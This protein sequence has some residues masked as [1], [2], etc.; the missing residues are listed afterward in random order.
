MSPP[1]AA[2]ARCD[3]T[4]VKF[5]TT[6]PEGRICR[7]CYQRAT[8]I[9]GTCPAC[10]QPRL[11]PGLIDAEPTCTD[12]A[13]IPKDFHCTR[14]GRE[15]EPVRTGLCAHCCLADDLALL[16][17]DGTG[18]IAAPLRPLFAALTTQKH[19]RSARAWLT[20]NRHAEQLLRDIAQRRAP[21]AHE[22]FR[23][24]P[25]PQKVAFL[26]ELCLEH[27]LLGRVNL[28]IERFQDWLESKA[29][30]LPAADAR[31]I[32]QYARWVHLNRMRH[33]ERRGELKK[34]TFLAAKQSTTMAIGFLNHLVTR[35]TMPRD[36]SQA[37]VDD[38]LATGPTTRSIARTFVRWAVE[39]GHI[40][41]VEFP[42]RT[43]QTTPVIGQQQRLDHI[44]ALTD[45]TAP[46]TAADRTIALFLLLYAQ[47]LTRISRMTL[48]QVEAIE[49]T[50]LV[51]F[52]GDRLEIPPPFD[53][54]VRAHLDALPNANTSSHRGQAWLFPGA[55]PGQHMHQT[56][57]MDRLR[58]LGIDLL[59]ARNAAL[60]ALVLEMP[61]PVVAGAFDYSYTVT[62]RHRRDAGATFTD[63]VT[64][65]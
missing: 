34:G 45:P 27:G 6:W 56:S 62:D 43:A 52:S 59:G 41:S 49:D 55:Q 16:L 10:S 8:R 5:A 28:D 26:R 36:C 60:R 46:I 12:C 44:R 50:I 58:E 1:P 32:R 64:H 15:D 30:A 18:S 48:D 3:R 29:E 21:L 7:R 40:P 11:L 61:A 31:L 25:V 2:C 57:I 35:G 38:W 53:G 51:S 20:V 14:C 37:D 63:Y 42:Y 23:D 54:V 9:H 19:A 65:R 24:H 13:G 4:G 33:L 47:P 39:H 22:T 17:D